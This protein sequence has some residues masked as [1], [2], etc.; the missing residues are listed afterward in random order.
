LKEEGST[1]GRGVLKKIADSGAKGENDKKRHKTQRKDT[2]AKAKRQRP[3]SLKKSL[4]PLK[5]GGISKKAQ[6]WTE[7]EKGGKITRKSKGGGGGGGGR[8]GRNGGIF[9][10]LRRFFR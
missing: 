1:E 2:G 3:I 4:G 8:E 7:K 10:G 6:G 5:E 9:P